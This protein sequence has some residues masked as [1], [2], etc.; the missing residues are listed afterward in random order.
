[1]EEIE[2]DEMNSS[3]TNISK[4]I[5]ND[6]GVL[7]LR[8]TPP[9]Q[10][11]FVDLSDGTETESGISVEKDEIISR[12]NFIFNRPKNA[13]YCKIGNTYA[14]WFNRNDEPRIVIGP[15]CNKLNE[16]SLYRAFLC[17]PNINIELYY[18]SHHICSP[19]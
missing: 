13:S 1:M 11:D 5:T 19:S 15:H 3:S 17:M 18:I 7:K 12:E 16:L 4:A 9:K 6:F 8:P 2:L 14:L 10:L